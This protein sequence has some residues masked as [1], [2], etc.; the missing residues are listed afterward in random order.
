MPISRENPTAGVVSG[1][2]IPKRQC[3]PF[4]EIIRKMNKLE[5]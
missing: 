4:M 1:P 5:I 2:S 3:W